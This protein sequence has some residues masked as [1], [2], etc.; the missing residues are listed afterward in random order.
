MSYLPDI[1]GATSARTVNDEFDEY[2]EKYF[3]FWQRLLPEG[4]R[5][6]VLA[7]IGKKMSHVVPRDIFRGVFQEHAQWLTRQEDY[8]NHSS[9]LRQRRSSMVCFSSRTSFLWRTD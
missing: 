4:E 1:H 8:I 5:Q 3:A 2:V 9:L 7:P 6:R